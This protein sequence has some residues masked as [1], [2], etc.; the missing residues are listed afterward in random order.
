MKIITRRSRFKDCRIRPDENR[1][2]HKGYM[3][4]EALKSARRTAPC[5][6]PSKGEGRYDCVDSLFAYLN[7]VHSR[8]ICGASRLSK[9]II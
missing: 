3:R 5:D 6:G 1:E 2:V 4:C 8:G 9:V 7:V